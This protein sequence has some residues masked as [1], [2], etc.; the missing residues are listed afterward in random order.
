[1]VPMR[2][3][4]IRAELVR[5][6]ITMSQ[7]ARECGVSVTLVYYVIHGRRSNAV[8][9]KAVARHLGMSSMEIFGNGSPSIAS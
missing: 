9:K 5:R 4:D 3:D 6:R 1:M 7:I 2:P 8:V